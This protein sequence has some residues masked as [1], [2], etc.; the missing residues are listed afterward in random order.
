MCSHFVYVDLALIGLSLERRLNGFEREWREVT[1]RE[2][3]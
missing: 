3:N 2:E 1:L